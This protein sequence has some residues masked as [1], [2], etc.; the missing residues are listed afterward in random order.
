MI[1][2][3]WS[4]IPKLS[5]MLK[6]RILLEAV[7]NHLAEKAYTII[8]GARQV[9]KTSLLRILYSE[10]KQKGEQVYYL[11][12][13]DLRVLEAID[14]HPERVFEFIATKPSRII[15]R[16]D[17]HR[18]FLLIDEVQYA[19]NPTNFLKFLFDTYDRNLK[20]V[21]TGSSAFYIDRSFKDSLAGRKRVFTL[22]P[23]SFAEALHF[24]DA[25][26]LLEELKLMHSRHDYKSL[27]LSDLQ[28][29]FQDYLVYGGYPAV[30]LERDEAGRRFLLEELKNAYVKR[31]I[32]ESS[33]SMETK[34][35][36]LFQ[37][38]ADQ[39]GNLLNKHE[40]ARTVQV[41]NKTID[42][43]LY[44]LEKC[45]HIYLLK[46]FFR[47]VRKELTKMPKVFFNDL[48]LRNAFLNRFDPIQRRADNGALLEQYFFC[49]LRLRYS[50]DQLKF[51]RTADGKEI[52]FIIEE[53]FNE[54]K[55]IEVK[56]EAGNFNPSKYRQFTDVYPGFELQ[57]W[58]AED[59]WKVEVPG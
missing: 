24:Q 5:E 38:L 47:N 17:E 26:Q 59:F 35:Y 51:W 34:F 39:V 20:V 14:Q 15:D 33:I 48:G 50:T 9:G 13:E 52:D 8:S 1:G 30:V 49:Q 55:A 37:L 43:Y 31:D 6:S 28:R 25:G 36:L 45:F 7:R 4:F 16:M 2:Y 57:C 22:T 10:L 21:C 19:K 40:L 27:Y 29:Y 12:F 41:D 46:P 53:R 23:L 54:G 58:S 32:L 42:N 56:W 3:F 18:V 11:T 44:V